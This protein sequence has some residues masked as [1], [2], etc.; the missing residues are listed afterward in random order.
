MYTV[1]FILVLCY[2]NMAVILDCT[3]T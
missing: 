2:C 3:D 1:I